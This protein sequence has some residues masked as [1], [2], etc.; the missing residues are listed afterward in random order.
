L[1]SAN[2][3]V[4]GIKIYPFFV[5]GCQCIRIRIIILYYALI[6]M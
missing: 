4:P 3:R 5:Q 6:Q 1:F 2:I